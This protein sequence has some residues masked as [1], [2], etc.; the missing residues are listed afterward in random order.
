MKTND[1]HDNAAAV[2]PIFYTVTEA[3]SLLRI[4]RA[5][6]YRAIREDGF[7]AVRVRSR[8]V[9]PAAAVERL[10]ADAVASGGCVNVAAIAAERRM[11]R[12]MARVMGDQ[13]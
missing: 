2:R 1:P 4:N 12:D 5:T 9:I 11:A 13:R 7:P 8:Y 6:L 10:V 3:A